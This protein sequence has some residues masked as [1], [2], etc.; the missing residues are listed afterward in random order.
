MTDREKLERRYRRL[1]AWYPR[2]FRREHGQELLAVL[3]D[4]APDGQRRPGLAASADLIRSGLG[5][6]LRPTVPRSARTVR[7]AVR[8]MYAGAAITALGLIISIISVGAFGHGA[9]GLRLLGHTQPLPVAIGMGIVGALVLIAL[10][11]WMAR[12][13]ARGQNWARVLSTVLVGLATLHLLGSR[14]VAAVVFAVVTWLLG[15]VAVSLLWHPSSKAFF[16]PHG[17]TQSGHGA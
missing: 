5:M 13:N 14:G 17:F 3:M 2:S 1:L 12:A 8:L 4:C 10:W 9:A 11:L 16:K 15:L 6:R 7:A